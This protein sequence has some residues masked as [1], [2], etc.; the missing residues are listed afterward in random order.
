MIYRVKFKV[1]D[2]QKVFFDFKNSADALKI[3][4]EASQY[5][6]NSLSEDKLKITM[7]IVTKENPASGN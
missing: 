5:V 2:Y 6:N 4:E 1:G 7:M 3:M